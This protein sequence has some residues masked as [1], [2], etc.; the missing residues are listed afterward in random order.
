MQKMALAV[1]IVLS[2]VS[3]SSAQP[4][5]AAAAVKPAPI[6]VKA[7][8]GKIDTITAADA[9]KNIKGSVVVIDDKGSKELFTV[10]SATV[11][12]DAADK[13]VASGALANGQ[14][15]NVSFI[16]KDDTRQAVAIKIQK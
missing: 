8:A 1:L 10:T 12:T 7:F 13:T 9:V 15:V 16:S 3:V 5:P 4:V 11:I 6:A 14:M 2:C